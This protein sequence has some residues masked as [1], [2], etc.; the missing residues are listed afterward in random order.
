MKLAI[1]VAHDQ[2][3]LI[4]KE[5]GL[6]WHLPE[7]LKHFKAVTLGKPVLM[8]RIVWEE[9]GEKP[10]PGRDNFV[11]TSREYENMTTFSSI[12]KALDGLSNYEE[13]MIIGGASIYE[14]LLG[15]V[16]TMIVTEVKGEYQ[17]DTWFPEYRDEIGKTW[18]AS[19]QRETDSFTIWRYERVRA[20]DVG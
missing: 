12:E 2:N 19:K 17:G 14:Q 11:L 9:I 15:R 8:G 6:P 5:G 3:L 1:V 4:G 7:D 10:L 20:A 16:Q 13:V 18:K